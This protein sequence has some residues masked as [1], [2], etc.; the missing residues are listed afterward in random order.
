MLPVPS[1]WLATL[2]LRE[3]ITFHDTRDAAR[4]F[5][6]TAADPYGALAYTAETAY[7][8][9]GTVLQAASQRTAFIGTVPPV[10]QL[11]HAAPR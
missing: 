7:L 4:E 11:P 1:A 10:R 5:I 9:T 3:K 6:V 2:R 8:A